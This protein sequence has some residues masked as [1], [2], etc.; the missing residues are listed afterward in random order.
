MTTPKPPEQLLHLL[1]DK[2]TFVIATHRGP[3]GD[4]LGSALGLYLALKA[5]G[6]SVLVAAPTH[7]PAHYRWMP[8][9]EQITVSL[10][11]P[12]EVGLV[13][14]CDGL[15]RTGD[16]ASILEQCDVLVDIG[17]RSG[18]PFGDIQ[19]VDTGACATTVMVHRL[20]QALN[21]PVT[22]EI[23]TCIYVGI[24]TDTGSFRFENTNAEAL[25]TA[26]D[27][28]LLGAM[29]AEIAEAVSESRSLSR[30]QLAGRA[31]SSLVAQADGRIVS[32]VLHPE[33]FSATGCGP[34]DTEGIVDWLKQV[35]GQEACVLFKAP[36]SAEKWQI[37]L[38]GAHIDVAEAARHFGGG[39]H[40]RAAGC[41]FD[42]PLEQIQHALLDM[43]VAAVKK[44]NG[45][46]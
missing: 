2:D 37:S 9:C 12:A 33:D 34:A 11:Q 29:P 31:L 17:H 28:A 44:A 21:W 40:P 5:Q 42:G 32:A 39:G 13:V 20:L 38:R 19:Y 6:K 18:A 45:G 16:L 43:L 35:E 25:H 10:A 3:D 14:D 36:F 24:S 1:R 41:D 27:M 15:D 22:S 30:M 26:G 8:Q 7:P 46:Q 23:A 4:A